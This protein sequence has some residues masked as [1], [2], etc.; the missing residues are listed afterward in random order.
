V[1]PSSGRRPTQW[2]PIDTAGPYLRI[3]PEIGTSCITV[4]TRRALQFLSLFLSFGTT[5]SRGSLS[6]VP[7]VDPVT[8]K[9]FLSWE[10]QFL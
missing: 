7:S 1:P 2:G 3:G 10:V 4:T 5:V 8:C 6:L 9:Q